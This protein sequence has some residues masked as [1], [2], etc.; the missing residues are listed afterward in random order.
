[1]TQA[2]PQ[3]LSVESIR[4]LPKTMQNAPHIRGM[5]LQV[6]RTSAT[7]FDVP[8]RTRIY[9]LRLSPDGK[10]IICDCIASLRSKC[11]HSW[12]ITYLYQRERK[13]RSQSLQAQP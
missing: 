6:Y 9:H 2:P 7:T 10:R 3:M 8:G 11:A 5:V 13:S 12:A 1:M 4:N